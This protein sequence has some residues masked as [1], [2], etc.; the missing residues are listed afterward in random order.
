MKPLREQDRSL[1]SANL[2]LSTK[3][4]DEKLQQFYESGRQNKEKYRKKFL[5]KFIEKHRSAAEKNFN[6]ICFILLSLQR[7]TQTRKDHF[8]S[9]NKKQKKKSSTLRARK[10]STC[11]KQNILFSPSVIK[12][13]KPDG[14]QRASE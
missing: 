10:R 3:D 12:G 14:A 2:F 4:D 9:L 7:Q 13:Y 11:I 8:S 6:R 5:E 1:R